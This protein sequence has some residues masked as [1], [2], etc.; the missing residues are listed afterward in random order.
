[1]EGKAGKFSWVELSVTLG[2]GMAYLGLASIITDVVLE[3][4]LPESETYVEHK[5][6]TIRHK[7][8]SVLDKAVVAGQ[9][10]SQFRSSKNIKFRKSTASLSLKSSE[11]L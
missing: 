9:L 8:K 5:E 1:M 6:K 2:A 11:T 3:N 10:N 7:M 4:F